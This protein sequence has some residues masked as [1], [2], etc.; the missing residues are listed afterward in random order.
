MKK[1]SIK[2]HLKEYSIYQKRKTTIN[3]AFAA[4][5]SIPDVYSEEKLN[6]ALITLGQ[7]PDNKL[8]CVYCDKEEAQ[9]WDH[10]YGLVKDGKFSGYGHIIG[11]LVP[12]CKQCNS[13]KGNKNWKDFLKTIHLDENELL[14]RIEKISRYIKE[15]STQQKS[16]LDGLPEDEKRYYDIQNKILELMK[17]ADK[18]LADIRL[19][20]RDSNK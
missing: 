18:L 4:A 11:N 17:E 9:T 5:L 15:N 19:K 10:I 6:K 7:N 16:L 3:N 14:D 2:N 8:I 20:H 1:D 12:C 13:A